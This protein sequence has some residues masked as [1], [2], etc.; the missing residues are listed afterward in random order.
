MRIVI[1]KTRNPKSAGP[2]LCPWMI[3]IPPEDAK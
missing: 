2:P 3:G 1:V